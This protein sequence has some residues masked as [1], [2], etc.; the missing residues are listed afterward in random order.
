MSFKILSVRGCDAGW[1]PMAWAVMM[2][3][4]SAGA[5]FGADAFDQS[6][7]RWAQVLT[8]FVQDARVNYAGL[9]R[10]PAALDAYLDAVAAIPAADF[11][12]WNKSDRLALL[13]NLYNART[14]RLITEHYPVKSIRNIGPLPG[15]AWREPT[16]RFGGRVLSL[17][18]LEHKI[19]RAEYSEPRIHFAVV[20]AAI[21]CP[22]LR[23]EPYT[24]AQLDDQLSDQARRF[25]GTKEKNRFDAEKNTLHLSYIFKWY[26]D[27]FTRA[28]GSVAAYVKPF[29]PP[30]QRDAMT[31]P[32]AVKLKFTEYDWRLNKR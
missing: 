29:L 28:S 6:H 19:I 20:C 15:S 18:E 11:E 7:G 3:W 30:A 32:G 1:V 2:G 22:P 27:D 5:S 16:V 21:G 4:L 14:L 23:Q 8:E 13:I 25:L 10:K 31:N 9:K 17:D 12:K 24:G 26:E